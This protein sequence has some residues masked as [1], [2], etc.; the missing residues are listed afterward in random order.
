MNITYNSN[1]IASASQNSSDDTNYVPTILASIIVGLL[2]IFTAIY[3]Y[4]N[5]RNKRKGNIKK[6]SLDKHLL[7]PI[8]PCEE[9]IFENKDKKVSTNIVIYGETNDH[10]L[11]FENEYNASENK[12]TFT[13]GKIKNRA[14]SNEYSDDK[15]LSIK[16]M[17]TNTNTKIGEDSI[18]KSISKTMNSVNKE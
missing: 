12:R 13:E 18:I 3:C 1:P 4:I 5:I 7:E 14:F 9:I 8:K 11:V 17:T 10:S 2:I 16:P 6:L 15:H